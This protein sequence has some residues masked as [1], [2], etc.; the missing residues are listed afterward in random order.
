MAKS[1]PEIALPKRRPAPK[2]A[3]TPLIR[4]LHVG[5]RVASLVIG[6]AVCVIG[7][8]SLIGLAT[9]SAGAR[10]GGALALTL[11]IPGIIIYQLHPKDGGKL[12][13]GVIPDLAGIVL[14]AIALI[15]ALPFTSTMF[16]R[17]GDRMA[18][19]GAWGF[20]VVTYWLG[21]ATAVDK[22]PPPASSTS[23]STSAS[24]PSA[25]AS[26]KGTGY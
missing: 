4:Q 24:A 2:K 6:V 14:M 12:A 26:G 22:M 15:F 21:G 18:E 13:P 11:L 17:E 25:S 20:A 23:A 8:A 19:S 10:Y 7:F 1:D 9:P 5:A 16:I 3:Q